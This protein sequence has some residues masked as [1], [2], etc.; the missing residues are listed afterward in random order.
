MHS[1]IQDTFVHGER[2]KDP[3]TLRTFFVAGG[4]HPQFYS[5]NTFHFV[6]KGQTQK[7]HDASDLREEKT[8]PFSQDQEEMS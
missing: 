5:N 4:P 2:L 7:K 8:S 6:F 3:N 1:A